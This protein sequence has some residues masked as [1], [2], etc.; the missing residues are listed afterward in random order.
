MTSKVY[1]ELSTAAANL[2]FTNDGV[3]QDTFWHVAESFI[4]GVVP[5]ADAGGGVAIRTRRGRLIPYSTVTSDTAA[6]VTALRSIADYEVLISGVSLNVLVL[7][8][9]PDK[10][11]DPQLQNPALWHALC[12]TDLDWQFKTVSQTGL[13]NCEQDLPAGKVLGGS[14]AINGAAFLPP[15]PAGIDTWS[16]LGNSK[17]SWKDLLPYLRQTFT[18]T[19][20]RG[21]PLSEVGLNEHV[22]TGAGGPIQVTYPALAEKANHPLIRAWN[23]VF[24]EKG[25]GFQP[26]LILEGSTVGAR[27]HTA[28]VD[29]ESGLRSSA[30]IEYRVLKKKYRPNLHIVTGVT[31][32]RIILSNDAESNEVLATG[33]QVR[34]ADGKLTEI[35]A[36]NEVILAAGA[37]Q[38]PKLLELSGIGSKAVLA[39]Y[40]ITPIIDN[41][42]VGENLQ[43]HSMYVQPVGLKP[44]EDTVTAGLQ[45]LAFVRTGEEAHLAARYLSP[46]DPEKVICDNILRNSEEA[47]ANFFEHQASQQRRPPGLDSVLSLVQSKPEVDPRFYSNPVDIELMARHLQSLFQVAASPTLQPFLDCTAV[48]VPEDLEAAKA[49]LRASALT[50]HHSCGTAAM[51]P[52]EQG[53]VVDQDLKVYGTKNLRVVDA[54]VFP[55]IPYGNPMATVYAVAE[56]AADLIQ[57]TVDKK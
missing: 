27:P 43:N 22:H 35:K 48:Q 46:T 50:T 54:S 39:R 30:D 32:D 9:G 5:L 38:T 56:R 8:A 20:P 44:Q 28:T 17:W 53:G 18:L 42:G 57:S 41:P 19:T 24:Q 11:S 12:G 29:P 10:T 51:L 37:F 1:P 25:Y 52:R 33:V 40:G 34:L 36:T 15:S 21:I 16:R 26:D 2:T 47:S 55:L 4:K 6:F 14:S 7:E 45:A 31:V 23:K 13:N 49:L 3:S